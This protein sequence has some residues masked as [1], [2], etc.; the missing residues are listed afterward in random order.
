M[1]LPSC[2]TAYRHTQ[3]YQQFVYPPALTSTHID[4]REGLLHAKGVCQVCRLLSVPCA[5]RL[6]GV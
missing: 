6:R 2:V 4:Y 1:L 3:A 5:Y